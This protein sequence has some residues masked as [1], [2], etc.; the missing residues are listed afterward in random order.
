MF[1]CGTIG[2]LCDRQVINLDGKVNREAFFALETGH[3]ND[4]LNDEGIDIVIDHCKIIELFL[5]IK[6]ISMKDSCTK[7]A[8]GSMYPRC[9]WYAFRRVLAG[10]N[11]L[12][13]EIS[14][15]DSAASRHL[16]ENE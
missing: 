9:G 16:I 6:P 15:P 11:S 12:A 8:V 1:Q 10:T 14:V 7:V 13:G 4:Y 5:G 3:I 2:Y